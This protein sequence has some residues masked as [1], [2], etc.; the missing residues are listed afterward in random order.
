MLIATDKTP[1]ATYYLPSNASVR[2][3]KLTRPWYLYCINQHAPFRI[4]N[5][6]NCQQG[7]GGVDCMR[8]FIVPLTI[9]CYYHSSSLRKVE[10]TASKK[11]GYIYTRCRDVITET[12]TPLFV[13]AGGGEVAFIRW[14][15]QEAEDP[16]IPDRDKG[17]R[18]RQDIPRNAG[19]RESLTTY[20]S[21]I[22][23]YGRRT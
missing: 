8:A 18:L 16:L 15:N 11:L 4:C 1:Y 13:G 6:I 19:V 23:F 17:T 22:H 20:L 10:C 12:E 14:D 5:P 2:M 21:R 3:T 7:H 9:S